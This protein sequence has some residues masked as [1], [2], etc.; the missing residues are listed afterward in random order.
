MSENHADDRPPLASPALDKGL[1]CLAT[2]LLAILLTFA[3]LAGAVMIYLGF[4]RWLGS[5]DLVFQG[6]SVLTRYVP[7]LLL[8]CIALLLAIRHRH[9]HP[10]QARLLIISFGGDLLVVLSR[11]LRHMFYAHLLTI[12]TTASSSWSWIRFS[13]GFGDSLLGSLLGCLVLVVLFG[14]PE[15][16]VPN[17]PTTKGLRGPQ[18]S[19]A[20]IFV[21]VTGLAIVLSAYVSLARW[22]GMPTTTV[23]TYGLAPISAGLPSL[24]FRCVA[25]LLAV[26]HRHRQPHQARLLMI[27]YGGKLASL[28]AI[29][30]A[31][32]LMY[33]AVTHN[34]SGDRLISL[35][36]WLLFPL[37]NLIW[38]SLILVVLFRRPSDEAMPA[39]SENSGDNPFRQPEPALSPVGE[40]NC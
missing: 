39:V 16:E 9:R 24:V 37:L 20:G 12:G 29:P 13:Q 25:L 40:E 10:R 5:P 19:L 4:G 22:L 17:R 30:L 23:F 8:T 15:R 14:K 18:F 11:P 28:L 27:A 36:V 21:L 7:G 35:A 38:E 26:R 32:M 31:N 2:G 3:S 34:H 33:Y 1:G 6:V